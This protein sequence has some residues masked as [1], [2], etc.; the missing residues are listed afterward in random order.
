MLSN[1]TIYYLQ[2]TS[3]RTMLNEWDMLDD[4]MVT[5]ANSPA[6]SL[7]DDGPLEK[8]IRMHLRQLLV[9]RDLEDLTS[10]MVGTCAYL[11][12][13]MVKYNSNNRYTVSN[14]VEAGNI[15]ANFLVISDHI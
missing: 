5:R 4:L 12:I 7:D 15:F 14:V 11:P 13:V 9:G 1:D 2:L 3:D 6:T 8:Q 10:Y